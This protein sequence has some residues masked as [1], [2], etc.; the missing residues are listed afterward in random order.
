[1]TT[2]QMVG[3]LDA[4]RTIRIDSD[5]VPTAGPNDVLIKVAV[6]GICG[7]DLA[8]YREGAPTS[9][10]ILG[11]EFSGEV[12]ATGD[13]VGGIG[14][15][16]R[17]VANPMIDLVGLGRVAGAFAEFLRL[18]GAE[19]GRNIFTLPPA[20]S[21]EV[22]AMIEPF[23]VGLHAVNRSGA[24]AGD[25]VAIFGAGSIGLCVLAALRSR[26]VDG[27]VMV[28]PSEKRRAFASA[29]GASDVHDPKTGS[30]SE[31]VGSHF[32]LEQL[33][34]ASRA[35]ALADIV[36][37]CAG[38]PA[39]L[40]DAIHSLAQCGRLVLVADPHDLALPDLRLVMLREL[41]VFGATGYKDE[42]HEAIDLLASGKVDLA[43]LVSH[44]FPLEKL[45][46]A[47]RTQMDAEVAIKVLVSPSAA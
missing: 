35:I 36:F 3:R 42:F 33:P 34:Y 17:V 22:G 11:H 28:D 29:M 21:D 45:D 31:F 9:G 46:E 2:K 26:G 10:A 18:P 30:S 16:D 4:A 32:G 1:M 5:E 47:F 39:T 24:K 41:E 44:R 8:F 12:I 20:I 38:V 23:A 27:I 13:Q 7:T 43:P 37:D 40:A 6:T 15:G 25:K 14:I 19:A